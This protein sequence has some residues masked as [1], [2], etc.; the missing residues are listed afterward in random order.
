MADEQTDDNTSGA[1]AAVQTTLMGTV[2]KDGTAS[3][4]GTFIVEEKKI[5]KPD[6]PNYL[7]YHTAVH[8]SEPNGRINTGLGFC[9]NTHMDREGESEHMIRIMAKAMAAKRAWSAERT[10]ADM[11]GETGKKGDLKSDSKEKHP[12]SEAVIPAA[13]SQKFNHENHRAILMT[14]Q[15]MT[16]N[17]VMEKLRKILQENPRLRIQN[18]NEVDLVNGKEVHIILGKIIEKQ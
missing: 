18:L 4:P 16:L 17:E 9:D 6:D 3:G 14:R 11:T 7:A 2:H 15:E 13:L 8:C 12:S 5:T 10:Y 1:T